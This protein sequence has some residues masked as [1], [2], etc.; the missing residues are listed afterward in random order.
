[1]VGTMSYGAEW[2]VAH[3]FGFCLFGLSIVDATL[4]MLVK[5][6]HIEQFRFGASAKHILEDT[7][8][9]TDVVVFQT[10][11]YMACVVSHVI[12]M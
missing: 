1:M 7:A 11:D 6:A 9:L 10:V 8:P 5:Q 2:T 3:A 4:C 12:A